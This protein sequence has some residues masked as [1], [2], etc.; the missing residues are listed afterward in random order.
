MSSSFRDLVTASRLLA[1]AI[2]FAL[3]Q[4]AAAAVDGYVIPEVDVGAEHHS[5]IDVRPTNDQVDSEVDGY[6][7]GVGATFGV[8]SLRGT[9]EARPRVDFEKYPDRDE[10]S[11]PN[12]YFDLKSTY[13]FQRDK[14]KMIGHYSRE[15]SVQAEIPEAGFDQFD[16]NNPIDTTGSRILLQAETTTRVQLRPEYIHEF[17]E[18][19]GAGVSAIYQTVNFDSDGPTTR[20]DNDY[21]QGEGFLTWKLDQRTDLRTG[22]YGARYK[23]DDD[24]NQTDAKGVSLMLQRSWT[25]SLSGF[26]QLNAERTEVDSVV[27]AN[28]TPVGPGTTDKSNSWG[29]T[30]GGYR[31]TP[32]SQT[33]LAAGRTLTP[34]FAGARAEVDELH[35]EYNRN[36]SERMMLTSALRGTRSR[37]Q[38][39]DGSDDND[40]FVG[41]VGARYLITRTWYVAGGY[42]YIWQRFQAD[43]TSGHDNVFRIRFGYY[44]LPPQ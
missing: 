39:G 15:N 35:L 7:A 11:D 29:F 13:E 34:S 38:G 3:A 17:T 28:G 2:G 42:S 27:I 25:Q 12:Y 30:V 26:V 40:D 6:S 31:L 21:L 32:V 16:P 43:D 44:G 37:S 24:T 5:N 9:T 14:L 22:L 33:Y 36:L 8:R 20:R 23:T 4:S 19:V 41:E 1:A 10:L 18:R